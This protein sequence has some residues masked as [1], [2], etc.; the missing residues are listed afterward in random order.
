[1]NKRL[2]I[3]FLLVTLLL[4][5]QLAQAQE[6]TPPAGPVYIVQAGDYLSTI[7]S[8]FGVLLDELIAANNNIDPNFISVGDR[9]VIP[10]L[11]G[12]DGVTLSTQLIGYGDTLRSLS[13]RNQVP[14]DSLRKLNHITSPSE[15]YAGV[16]LLLPQKDNFTPLSQRILINSGESLLEAAVLENSDP[17]TLASVNELNGT[18]QAAPGDI[19]YNPIGSTE[20]SGPSGMPSAFIKA[21]VS[22][23]PMIQGDTTTITVQAAPGVTLGGMLA[24]QPLHFFSQEDGSFVALQGLH[25][26]LEPGA[27]PLRLDATLPDGIQQSY[28]QMV[29]IKSG[30]YPNDPLLPVEPAFIDPAV[31]VPELEQLTK[32]VTPATPT[33]YWN[34]LFQSPS[35]FND[36]FT[37]RYGNR[38]TYIG[39]GTQ[40]EI[41]SFHSGLDFCG[42]AGVQIFAP[43]DGVVVFAGPLTVRGNATLID[44]GWGVYSGIWHQSEI[45]VQ[46]GQMVKKGDEIGL[47]GRTGRVTGAHLHWEIWVNGIQVNPMDWLNQTFP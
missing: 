7:A 42:G 35:Y 4:P 18:W 30:N 14:E 9:I 31:T 8:R 38:R 22:P 1:M 13:R 46:V 33:R 36:C 17:W 37:S 2:L 43:A 34:G 3:F 45:K 32:L 27:Y 19:L 6:V 28:E 40:E 15:L 23:L 25:A 24:D 16:D 47:I 11:Q 20:N 29:L 12:F 44:H 41:T 10:G 21:N 5:S 26:M 39:S